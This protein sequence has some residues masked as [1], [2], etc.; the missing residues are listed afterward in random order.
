MPI[1]IKSFRNSSRRCSALDR[2]APRQQMSYARL[3]GLCGGGGGVRSYDL[4]GEGG[5]L[6]YIRSL[7]IEGPKIIRQG[8]KKRVF[9][10]NTPVS[11]CLFLYSATRGERVVHR[12][13]LPA[14]WAGG[15]RAPRNIPRAPI[16]KSHSWR[17]PIFI[18]AIQ[19]HGYHV[20]CA[21]RW[22]G[23]K[24]WGHVG[25]DRAGDPPGH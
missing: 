5:L 18:D 12:F 6:P 7:L 10:F 25:L 13:C 19:C 21:V 4:R 9:E 15:G 2:W 14:G 3:C 8:R 23:G 11:G 1:C 24:R 17:L 16:F 20:R 22:A